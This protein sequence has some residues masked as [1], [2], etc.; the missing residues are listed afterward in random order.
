VQSN[1]YPQIG[2]GIQRGGKDSNFMNSDS[3]APA[4][5]SARQQVTLD[6]SGKF[7]NLPPNN[8]EKESI[9]SE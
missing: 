9:Q 2:S 8:I 4:S 3:S 7:G 6:T 5:S 1:I